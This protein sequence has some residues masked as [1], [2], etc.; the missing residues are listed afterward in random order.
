MDDIDFS[1]P[2]DNGWRMG[3][4]DKCNGFARRRFDNVEMT[5]YNVIYLDGYNDAYNSNEVRIDNAN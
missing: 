2:Y 4:F 5:S 1:T 3:T